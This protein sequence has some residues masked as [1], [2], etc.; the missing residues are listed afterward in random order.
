MVYASSAKYT[1]SIFM[2]FLVFIAA[3]RLRAPAPS[4]KSLF[5]N[6]RRFI[7][8]FIWVSLTVRAHRADNKTIPHNSYL[9]HQYGSGY[10]I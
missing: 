10:G 9:K 1:Y 4:T 8:C 2:F 5:L 6:A 7:A 3:A